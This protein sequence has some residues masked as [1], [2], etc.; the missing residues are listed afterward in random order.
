M[1][2]PASHA[3]HRSRLAVA[4]GL[5]ILLVAVAA[6]QLAGSASGETKQ[7]KL[8]GVR[9]EQSA[10]AQQV[11]RD[12]QRVDALIGEV[13]Q[14]R[15]Q[16]EAADQEL[17][18]R[19]S[20]LRQAT[21]ALDSGRERL[22][23]LRDK[24]ARAAKRL[25]GMLVSMYKN[26]GDEVAGA[27]L[28][29]ESFGDL[30]ARTEYLD[31]INDYQSGVI[32]R[33][34][35]LR[36][37]TDRLVA[38]MAANRQRVEEARDAIAARRDELAANR[39]QAEAQQAKLASAYQ[40]RKAALT[41]LNGREQSL[42]H[43][44]SAQATAAAAA[45][46]PAPAPEPAPSPAPEPSSSGSSSDS[47]S[48][49]SSSSSPAP[50]TTPGATATIGSDGKAIP[51]ADAPPAVVAAIEAANQIEDTPYV[52]GGGHGSFDSSGY[53]C[54]GAVSYALHGGG[55]LSSPLDSTG[56]Q[57]WGDS[58]AGNW[59]TVYANAGHAYAVIAGLRWDTSGTGG[60]GPSWSTSL[61]GY[62]DPSAY[63]V[64]HPPG[65]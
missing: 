18:A 6:L 53:D 9:A 15:Q 26:R 19:E 46:E 3:S 63:T 48:S 59:I 55:L 41:S 62:L 45:A 64:R 50:A 30:A 7:E 16:E 65:L 42:Q 4:V 13:S 34:T 36:D 8:A 17:A 32:T 28:S 49:S 40:Q 57:S 23:K 61:D 20:E 38:D 27:L 33:A 21:A 12:N 44:I 58:G 24:L 14:L 39:S 51:P 29:S 25:R 1:P 37:K 31:R 35:T 60:S 52:W 2:F 56:L 22:A 47:G 10:V 11:Q 5:A 43:R 54:S